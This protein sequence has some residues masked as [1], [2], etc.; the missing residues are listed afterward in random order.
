MGQI[1]ICSGPI[2]RS[3]WP[4]RLPLLGGNSVRCLPSLHPLTPDSPSAEIVE[5]VAFTGITAWSS[6]TSS[7]Y[8]VVRFLDMISGR[9][10]EMAQGAAAFQQPGVISSVQPSGKREVTLLMTLATASN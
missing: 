4:P 1:F 3:R 2:Q 9:L 8:T 7:Q 5:G 10:E 6:N